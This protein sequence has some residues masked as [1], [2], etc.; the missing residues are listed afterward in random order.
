MA[1][2][3]KSAF[4]TEGTQYGLDS[5]YYLLD[6]VPGPGSV[7]QGP[8]TITGN[9]TTTGTTTSQGNLSA[10]AVATSNVTSAATLSLTA[11]AGNVNIN[12]QGGNNVSLVGQ[13]LVAP[14][15]GGVSIT[16]GATPGS[17]LSMVPDGTINLNGLGAGSSVKIEALSGPGIGVPRSTLLLPAS[18]NASLTGLG[19][20]QIFGGNSTS[21]VTPDLAINSAVVINNKIGREN[22]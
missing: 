11:S 2:Q 8:I 17:T 16:S 21:I 22:V 9:L 6:T 15:L 4:A 1:S 13:N 20:L 14:M 3:T 5:S 19:N 12:A 10:P 18:G 7:L